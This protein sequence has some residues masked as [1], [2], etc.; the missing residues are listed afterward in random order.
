MSHEFNVKNGLIIGSG[1]TQP[2]NHISNNSALTYDSSSILTENAVK[3]AIDASKQLLLTLAFND[4]NSTIVKGSA[5]KITTA[6]SLPYITLANSSLNNNQVVGLVQN[7]ILSGQTGYIV[8]QGILSGLNITGFTID[9]MIYCSDVI[10]GGYITSNNLKITSRTNQIGYITQTGVTTGKIFVQIVNEQV[11]TYLTMKESVVMAGNAGSTGVYEFQ[12]IVR[13]SNTTFNI[14]PVKGWIVQNTYSNSNNPLITYIMYSGVT[15]ATT[16]YINIADSSHV[17]INSASTIFYLSTYP[18]PQQRRENIYLGKIVHTNRQS[19]ISVN[20]NTDYVLSTMSSLRDMFN[21]MKLINDGVAVSAN[22][23]NMMINLSSGSLFGM[24]INWF[25]NQLNPNQVTIN[26]SSPASF[27]YRTQTGGTA[28]TGTTINPN[29]YDL[30]G[31]ITTI[32]NNGDGGGNRST[33]QRVYLYPTGIINIQ[34]GQQVYDTLALALAGQQTEIFIKSPNVA[35][36]GILIGII[37]VRRTT[38]NLSN[39]AY[40]IFTPASMFGESVGGVNGISTTTLQQAYEN[41]VVPEI[42]TNSTLGSLMIKVGTGIDTDYTYQSR[43]TADANTFYVMGNGRVGIQNA[44]LNNEAINLQQ[45]NSGLT[46]ITYIYS[47][48]LTNN[49]N[50]ITNNLITGKAGG[51]TIIGGTGTTDM[52]VIKGTSGNGT[53]TSTGISFNVGNNGANS[54]MTILNNGNIGIGTSSPTYKLDISGSTRISNT[55]YFGGTASSSSDYS[56]SISNS[57]VTLIIK[58]RV[59]DANAFQIQNSTGTTGFNF[60]TTDFTQTIGTSNSGGTLNV[61]S[62]LGP[63]MSPTLEAANWTL[64]ADW[65]AGGGILLKTASGHTT[66]ATPSGAFNVLANRTY[67]VVINYTSGSSYLNY[68]IGGQSGTMLNLGTTTITDYI[69]TKTTGKIIFN[70]DDLGFVGRG[71]IPMLYSYAPS[72][73]GFVI[74]SLTFKV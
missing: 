28:G 1:N 48:G 7:D 2:V 38:T 53:L 36:T 3:L 61:K 71:I 32:P 57:S 20:N 46:N 4:T 39:K 17:M 54:A 69:T 51:Q 74:P 22:D 27:Y 64:G 60:S 43:N 33:N 70:D 26:A 30:N 37:A 50:I 62:T 16:P 55:L 6:N 9:D 19:I 59:D 13:T 31:T 5:V 12:G 15:G 58:P 47:S 73:T 10:D 21:S 44:V 40:A 63:E 67:K 14:S 45:F 65:S 35:E 66:T 72:E 11:N 23:T 56:H 49:S 68:I 41:S 34:Y 18:T 8:T 42:T 24:G 25:N 29:V 52:L